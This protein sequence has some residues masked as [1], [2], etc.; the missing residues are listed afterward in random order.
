VPGFAT[1]TDDFDDNSRDLVKWSGSY[2]DVVEAGG[3]ARVPCTTAF[4]AYQSAAVYTLDESQVACRVFAPAAGGATTEALAEVLVITSTG[5]TDGGFSINTVTG[6]ISMV[7]RSGYFDGSAV[8]LP[9]S[10]TAHAWLRLRESAGVL[11]WDTSPDGSTWTT[12]RS[13]ASP[14]WVNDANLSIIMA[15][16]RNNGTADFA[17][18]DN[19]NLTRSS[20]IADGNRAGTAVAHLA[21]TGSTVSGG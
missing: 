7:S 5:G 8:V 21:R 14:A 13:S 18:F 4:S 16:H 12:R 20:R 11:H 2:G 6:Q 17:E 9:Y 10:A 19:F 1:L 15:G 3:R